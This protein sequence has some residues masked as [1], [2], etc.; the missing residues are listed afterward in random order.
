MERSEDLT[1][2]DW[3]PPLEARSGR[4]KLCGVTTKLASEW[5]GSI[6]AGERGEIDKP[7]AESIAGACLLL[8]QSEDGWSLLTRHGELVFRGRGPDA[9]CRSLE[10]AYERGALAVLR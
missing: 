6:F 5:I 10:V 1:G 3:L 8:R 7:A 4:D 9:R 2:L